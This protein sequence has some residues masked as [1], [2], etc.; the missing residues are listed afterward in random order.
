MSTRMYGVIYQK[1]GLFVVTVVRTSDLLIFVKTFSV[2]V[3]VK[4][5]GYNLKFYYCL[6]FCNC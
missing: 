4:A 6:H 1:I 3:C 2:Y 5:V